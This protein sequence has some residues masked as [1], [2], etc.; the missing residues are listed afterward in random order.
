[1]MRARSRLEALL[2]RGAGWPRRLEIRE[3]VIWSIFAGYAFL[4]D[5]VFSRI[6]LITLPFLLPIEL[7]LRRW[8]VIWVVTCIEAFAPG[9]R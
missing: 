9:S 4:P 8:V 2:D 6:L 7:P 5:E 3:A 1:M